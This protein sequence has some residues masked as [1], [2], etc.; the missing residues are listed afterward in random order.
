[1]SVKPIPPYFAGTPCDNWDDAIALIAEYRPEWLHYFRVRRRCPR[2]GYL[3]VVYFVNNPLDHDPKLVQP[4]IKTA[5]C[6]PAALYFNVPWCEKLSPGELGWVL[7]HELLHWYWFDLKTGEEMQAECPAIYDGSAWHQACDLRINADITS[8]MALFNLNH[9]FRMPVGGLLDLSLLDPYYTRQRIYDALY[10]STKHRQELDLSSS[11]EL[12]QPEP[13][14][15]EQQ[16]QQPPES[17][18]DAPESPESPSGT[19]EPSKS[20]QNASTA[21]SG[22]SETQPPTENSEP[23]LPAQSLPE[24]PVIYRDRFVPE[25]LDPLD[26]E[27]Q[28][29]D[30]YR[31][32]DGIAKATQRALAIDPNYR[33]EDIPKPGDALLASISQAQETIPQP[34]V[35]WRRELRRFCCKPAPNRT[36][37]SRPNPTYYGL[38]RIMPGRYGQTMGKLLVILD[39]SSS[40][41]YDDR[42]PSLLAELNTISGLANADI[43]L[44]TFN[45]QIINHFEAFQKI[46]PDPEHPLKHL[47]SL[48]GGTYFTKPLT[49]LQEHQRKH[50]YKACVFITDGEDRRPD[51]ELK[52]PMPLIWATWAEW[53]NRPDYT[54]CQG[55]RT[56]WGKVVLI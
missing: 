1:M 41:V 32:I 27:D 56:D 14:E 15:D 26:P 43:D 51:D 24:A 50:R 19:P 54:W 6:G 35:D 30:R 4:N 40:V 20:P 3:P 38:G 37:W 11:Y 12:S 34:K 45:S 7:I 42:F 25:D 48:G 16:A 5:S 49:W 13:E 39:V 2:R 21:G 55:I 46:K 8:M 17:P 33:P 52:P 28:Q 9:I 29:E 22:D 10:G 18:P 36:R 23:E 53:E 47:G 31:R 44:L